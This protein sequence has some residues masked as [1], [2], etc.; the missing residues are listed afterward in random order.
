MNDMNKLKSFEF[1]VCLYLSNMLSFPNYV[2]R[3][4]NQKIQFSQDEYV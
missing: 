4:D 2:Y 1:L 3:T